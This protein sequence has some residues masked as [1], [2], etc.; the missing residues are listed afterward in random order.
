MDLFLGCPSIILDKDNKR[1]ELYGKAGAY[2]NKPYGVEYRTLSNFWLTSSKLM[3]WVYKRTAFALN[4]VAD[5]SKNDAVEWD[6]Y[7]ATAIQECI[8][9]GNKDAYM[10]LDK[11]YNLG[12]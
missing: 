8:N 1:R 5:N 6:I 7:T 12:L 4:W 2:R 11:Q 3:Q 9:K 10:F